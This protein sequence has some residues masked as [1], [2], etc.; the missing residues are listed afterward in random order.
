M[1]WLATQ[2]IILKV[3]EVRCQLIFRQS[4][5]QRTK[6]MYCQLCLPDPW[7]SPESDRRLI[8]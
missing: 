8:F 5:F 2:T 3:N 7:M 6:N 1:P 4:E